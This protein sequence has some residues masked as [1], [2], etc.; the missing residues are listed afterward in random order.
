MLANL[1]TAAGKSAPAD[2]LKIVLSCAKPTGWR[3]LQVPGQ[4]NLGWLHAWRQT[5]MGW[6]NS[7]WRHF[8]TA[9]ARYSDPHGNEG[10]FFGGDPAGMSARPRCF[11]PRQKP[12]RSLAMNM[13]LQTL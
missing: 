11:R 2:Q 12:A 5:A 13:I 8:L 4:A 9:D 7:H 6:T 1:E 3:V 10:M